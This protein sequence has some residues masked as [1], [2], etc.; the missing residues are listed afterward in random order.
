[1]HILYVRIFM[2]FTHLSLTLVDQQFRMGG[3]TTSHRPCRYSNE[4]MMVYETAA[5]I[6]GYTIE[7]PG[8]RLLSPHP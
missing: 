1:M 5:L 7:D 4:V 3:S 8:T 6:G 2:T